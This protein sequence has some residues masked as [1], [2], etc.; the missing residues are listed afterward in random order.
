MVE[1]A[2]ASPSRDRAEVPMN[3]RDLSKLPGQRFERLAT[4]ECREA[5]P[6]NRTVPASLSSETPVERWF[7]QEVLVHTTE[8]VDLSRAADG[9][10]MLWNHNTDQPIGVVDNIK[11]VKGKLRGFL[12]FS[13][14]A[15]AQEVFKDVQEGFL[16][17]ISIGYQV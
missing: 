4:L 6:E 1:K 13:N 10:P 12:R 8:A 9:V 3:Q 11:V 16:R 7:G 2:R 5:D 17:N 15:K 14:N